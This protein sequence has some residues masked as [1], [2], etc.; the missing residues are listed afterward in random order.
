MVTVLSSLPPAPQFGKL[1]QPCF[2]IVR[3]MKER[4]EGREGGEGKKKE[5]KKIQTINKWRHSCKSLGLAFLWQPG[6]ESQD[7]RHSS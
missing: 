5:K 2:K 1:N 7:L 4:G 6:K 3:L